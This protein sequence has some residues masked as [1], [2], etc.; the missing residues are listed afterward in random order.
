M[1][2]GS[3]RGHPQRPCKGGLCCGK[4]TEEGGAEGWKPL[5]EAAAESALR[6]WL[7]G[8]CAGGK[9]Q[10]TQEVGSYTTKKKKKAWVRFRGF[11]QGGSPGYGR[12]R[13]QL[14]ARLKND[15]L[16]RVYLGVRGGGGR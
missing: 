6:C 3:Q 8:M 1:L 2:W 14:Q 10:L 4:E 16:K 5:W 9:C 12:E 7:R 15:R 11:H 13:E